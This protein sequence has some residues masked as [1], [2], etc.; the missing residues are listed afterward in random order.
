M[1]VFAAIY[2][3]SYE[4]SLKIFE[5]AAKKGA[6]EIDHVRARV[7]IGKE[8]YQKGYIGHELLEEISGI[9]SGYRKIMEGYRTDDYMA[10][11]GGMFKGIKNELFVL[12]QLFIRT[13][14]RI[15]VDRKSVV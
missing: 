14:I 8:S 13:G 3:G 15:Q 5:I 1:K 2:I 4:A 7:E 6:R 10:Y 11:A 12:D 9:L